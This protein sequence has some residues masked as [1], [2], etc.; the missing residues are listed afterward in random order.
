MK[1][2]ASVI[3]TGLCLNLLLATA[4]FAGSEV[5]PPEVGGTVVTPP[6]GTAFTGASVSMWMVLA[7]ALFVAG[8]AFVVTSRRR[9]RSVAR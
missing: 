7:A 2:V 3:L 8:V 5:P 6:G 9:A 4:A 1:K